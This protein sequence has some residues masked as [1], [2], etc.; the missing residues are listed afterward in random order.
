[1]PK[2]YN[3]LVFTLITCLGG[4]Y[5][6]FFVGSFYQPQSYPPEWNF[7]QDLNNVNYCLFNSLYPSGSFIGTLL[8]GFTTYR[9]GRVKTLFVTDLV[10]LAGL[11]IMTAV[12]EF[13]AFFI[14]RFI[15]GLSTGVNFPLMLILIREFIL[16]EDYMQYIVYFQVLNTVGIMVSNLICLSNIYQ[17][18]IGIATIFPLIRMIYF[19]RLIWA[20][21]DTPLYLR[22]ADENDDDLD[23]RKKLQEIYPENHIDT[24]IDTLN[25][26]RTLLQK[27]F[28]MGN[29]FSPE[30]VAEIL[31]CISILFLNQS[32]GINQ[33][34]GYSGQFFPKYPNRTPVIFS[35]VNF[36]GGMTI[37]LTI[38]TG[39]HKGVFKYIF[40]NGFSIGF[41]RFIFG[42]LVMILI[43]GVFGFQIIYPCTDAEEG[44]DYIVFLSLGIVY[45]MV[46]QYS[47]IYVFIYI[48]VL[49]PDIGVFMVLVIHSTFGM[50]ASLSFYFGKD[51]F[52]VIFRFCFV[53]SIFGLIIAICIFNYFLRN[54]KNES[55]INIDKEDDKPKRERL[56][57]KE[58]KPR[59]SQVE[60]KS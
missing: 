52:P 40:T 4:F 15:M 30:Y 58:N 22:Y 59:G 47:M 28:F 60:L 51:T 14:G 11:I 44:K 38:Y 20:K 29:M 2:S 57:E 46:F 54:K 49:L 5:Y 1:M 23:C 41:M 19:F 3:P 31:F 50:I 27:D 42:T 7:N 36:I 6:G 18:A 34:L 24:L 37:L 53:S 16:E 55:I 12:P 17:L 35:I 48:P 39:K 8:A 43:L 56:L 45:L 33:V 21:I 9:F 25:E 32:C 26:Q 10:T 13:E